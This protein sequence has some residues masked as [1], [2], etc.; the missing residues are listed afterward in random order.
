MP[1]VQISEKEH[2]H[3][4]N[5]GVEKR[6]IFSDDADRWRFM[7]ALITAQGDASFP[8]IHRIVSLVKEMS[9]DKEIF[10][11]ILDSRYVELISFCLMPN[12][13]HL[14]VRELREG[15]ISKYMQRILTAHTKY[16]NVRHSRTG[17]LFGSKFQYRHIDTNKYL[18][19]LSAY[20]HL[21][22]RELKTWR[23]KEVN[24]PWSSF[25]DFVISN[26]WGHFLNTAIVLKQF[27][28]GNEYREFVEETPIK[29][30]QEHIENI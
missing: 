22:P 7:T 5:R 23:H 20:I 18:N 4:F 27:D 8:Q 17:H 6:I 26:R 24:Y 19:Y 13:F 28:N 16:F 12:H 2:Y 9:F 29:E 25:Q 11:K 10:Q 21:N 1:R 15:G 14:V 3:I 30:I